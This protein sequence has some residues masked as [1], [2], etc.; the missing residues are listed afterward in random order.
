MVRFH[1]IRSLLL[2][3]SILVLW[4][5]PSVTQAQSAPTSLEAAIESITDET[6]LSHLSVLA[7]RPTSWPRH[8]ERGSRDG[9]GISR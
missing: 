5:S 7:S 9:G 3:L 6:I 1:P 2:A 8:S 4:V